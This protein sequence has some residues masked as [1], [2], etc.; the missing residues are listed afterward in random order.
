MVLPF[1]MASSN[2]K[3]PPVLKRRKCMD[4]APKA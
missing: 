4:K 2:F 1:M 3:P